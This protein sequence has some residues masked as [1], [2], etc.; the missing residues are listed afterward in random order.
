M[1]ELEHSDELE[2][3][4]DL[5]DSLTHDLVSGRVSYESFPNSRDRFDTLI[6]WANE[7][8]RLHA[9][10]DWAEV[11]YLDTVEEWYSA[12]IRAEYGGFLK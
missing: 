12:K 3:F 9:A 5:T 11:E 4:Y 6:G 1:I 10:T 2:T 8:N 7:F